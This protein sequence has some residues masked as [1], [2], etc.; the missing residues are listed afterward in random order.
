MKY[1]G[2]CFLIWPSSFSCTRAA[3]TAECEAATY[4][5]NGAPS[6]G[7]VSVVRSIKYCFNSSKAFRWAGPHWKTS[8]HF[9][10]SKNGRFLSADLDMNMFNDASLPASRWAPFFVLGGSI[11]RIASILLGLAS[12]PFVDTKQPRNFPFFTPKTHFSGFN[13]R[14]ACL[15]LANVSCKSAMWFLASCFSL[16]YHQHRSVHSCLFEN[17]GPWLSFC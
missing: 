13:F 12:I 16:W 2:A 9:S 17:E 4:K 14:P 6:E 5:S 15:K 7:G 10:I 11:Q 8:A 1:T 3:L